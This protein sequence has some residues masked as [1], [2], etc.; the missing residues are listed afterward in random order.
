MTGLGGVT[1][2]S[3]ITRYAYTVMWIVLVSDDDADGT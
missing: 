3:T 2:R 1:V